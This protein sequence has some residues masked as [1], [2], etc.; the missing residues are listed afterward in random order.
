VPYVAAVILASEFGA[1]YLN[2]GSIDRLKYPSISAIN[3]AKAAALNVI[4]QY[5]KED[6]SLNDSIATLLSYY[7][8]YKTIMSSTGSF[9]SATGG[10]NVKR[11][12][13]SAFNAG[14]M[15]TVHKKYSY[16]F[17]VTEIDRQLNE[18][19]V[20]SNLASGS[21]SL[22]NVCLLPINPGTAFKLEAMAF[23]SPES[24][25]CS[26]YSISFNSDG[27]IDASINFV[28]SLL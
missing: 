8:L 1:D 17:L 27:N 26:D 19:Y 4:L 18:L 28:R 6:Y 21:V 14:N 9:Y 11:L 5:I 7:N 3:I 12:G 15:L 13:I 23:D 2:Y 22:L 24:V 20:Q 10:D 16:I 25:V